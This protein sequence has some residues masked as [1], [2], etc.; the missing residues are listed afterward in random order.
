MANIKPLAG[1]VLIKAVTQKEKT[2]SGV[3]LPETAEKQKP[4]QGKVMAVGKGKVLPSGER[5]TP[6]VKEGDKVIFNKYGPNKVK[7]EDEEYLIAKEEDILA[8]FE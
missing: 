2:E 6:E 8:I 3:Y 5:V 4:E 1:K 7:V